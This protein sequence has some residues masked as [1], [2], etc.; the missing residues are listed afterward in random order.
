MAKP[1][2]HAGGCLCGA[3]R[4]Q[5]SGEIRDVVT[6]HCEQCRRTSGHHVAATRVDTANL[7]VQDST[8]SLRWYRSSEKA[9]RAFCSTCGSNLF[10]SADADERTSIMAGTLDQPTGLTIAQHIYCE[11]KADY[12]E[13]DGNAPQYL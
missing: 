11:D 5:I 2:F 1:N 9:Q 3:I 12:Y 7:V 10:W 4:Y 8:N 6:C 13:I